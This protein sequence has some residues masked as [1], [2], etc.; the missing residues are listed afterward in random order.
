[1]RTSSPDL[2]TRRP[3]R[4]ALAVEAIVLVGAIGL[5]SMLAVGIGV[6]LSVY[7]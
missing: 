1:M 7:F 4:L 2:Q 6:L 5:G 3:S